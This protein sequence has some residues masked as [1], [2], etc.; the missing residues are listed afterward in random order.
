MVTDSSTLL[1]DAKADIPSYT[2]GT[3]A[4]LLKSEGDDLTFGQSGEVLG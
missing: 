2:D 1:D 4:A 3:V